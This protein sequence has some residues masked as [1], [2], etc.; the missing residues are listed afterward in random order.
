MHDQK[1]QFGVPEGFATPP[2]PTGTGRGLLQLRPYARI[3]STIPSAGR[4]TTSR[5]THG[6][7]SPRPRQCGGRHAPVSARAGAHT[8]AAGPRRHHAFEHKVLNPARPR[9][10]SQLPIRSPIVC[11]KEKSIGREHRRRLRQCM[12]G[13]THDSPSI[14][15]PAD[16]R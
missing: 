4:K 3:A 7:M 8:P 13:L 2:F 5:G 10:P 12:A 16:D 6:T 15:W 11:R 1:L 9:P 14:A